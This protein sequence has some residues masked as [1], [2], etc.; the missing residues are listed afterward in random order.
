MGT[1]WDTQ[2]GQRWWTLALEYENNANVD[3]ILLFKN[4]GLGLD[5]YMIPTDLQSRIQVR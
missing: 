5:N 2:E 1:G 4:Q 3:S